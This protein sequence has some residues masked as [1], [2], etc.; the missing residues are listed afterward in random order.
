MPAGIDNR[1]AA[2]ASARLR[3]RIH[4][5][6]ENPILHA[7]L[8]CISHSGN[9]Y[10]TFTYRSGSR[11]GRVTFGRHLSGIDVTA[12]NE[13]ADTGAAQSDTRSSHS[14]RFNFHPISDRL[15][16]STLARK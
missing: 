13:P 12:G 3:W 15:G 8:I 9:R 16:I 5:V 1:N 6:G 10:S 11:V 4:D 14:E 2:S 7:R